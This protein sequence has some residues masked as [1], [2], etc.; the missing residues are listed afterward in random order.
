MLIK[1]FLYKFLYI[2]F[3]GFIKFFLLN[4]FL[5]WVNKFFVFDGFILKVLFY[6]NFRVV[7]S[8]LL[9]MLLDVEVV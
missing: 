6:G 2:V 4:L 5:F 8:F 7:Y 3:I 1:C 9:K